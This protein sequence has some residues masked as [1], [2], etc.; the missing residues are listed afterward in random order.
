MAAIKEQMIFPY[1][2]VGY[3]ME[4]GGRIMMTVKRSSVFPAPEEVIFGKLQKLE[5]LQYI[6]YPYAIFI[7]M[8]E[9]DELIWEEGS[10]NSF[11]FKIFGLIPFG[12]H[13]IN[14]IRFG[15]GDGIY[16]KECN[17]YVPIWNHEIIME[18]LDESHTKYTDIVDIEA[19]WKTAFVYLWAKAFYMHRQKKWLKLL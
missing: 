12:I 7:P 5:T 3:D 4:K 19:G 11:R 13:T 17:Q 9:T 10:S 8:D 18:K 16:T 6:A 2:A 14:V 1:R 15:W